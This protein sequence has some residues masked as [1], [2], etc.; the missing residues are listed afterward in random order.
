[1]GTKQPYSSVASP[2]KLLVDEEVLRRG[3]TVRFPPK[4]VIFA[5][6]DPADKIFYL[7]SG[8]IKLYFMSREGYE[9]TVLYSEE[10]N[11]FGDAGMLR[12]K[13]YGITAVTVTGCEVVVFTVGQFLTLFKENTEFAE[14]CLYSLAEKL[15]ATGRQVNNLAFETGYGKVV[16]ALAYVARHSGVPGGQEPGEVRVEVT[17]QELAEMAGVSRVTVSATLKD[18]Q[19]SNIISTSRNAILVQNL[20]LLRL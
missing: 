13:P 19:K 3:L 10:G 17:Q 15:W 14:A 20:E 8:M 12:G 18:L 5:Q 11:F 2:K 7:R 1:M 6:G 16:S 4:A 9:K